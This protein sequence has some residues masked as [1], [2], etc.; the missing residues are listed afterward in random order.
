[1]KPFNLAHTKLIERAYSREHVDRGVRSIVLV[2]VLMFVCVLG[3]GYVRVRLSGES[4]LITSQIEKMRSTGKLDQKLVEVA[5]KKA[6]VRRWQKQLAGGTAQRFNLLRAVILSAPPDIWI[7]RV[8]TGD[9]GAT[10]S[11]EGS[12]ATY[13]TLA[14]FTS[15]LRDRPDFAEVRLSSAKSAGTRQGR[16]VDF[17]VE[18]DVTGQNTAAA[19]TQSSTDG[20]GG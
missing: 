6:L 16:S 10:L 12:A 19:Q 2:V 3:A 4:R 1:M 13:G 7:S 14:Q 20:R 8:T 18:V 17:V 15:N 9:Q 5:E 11:I